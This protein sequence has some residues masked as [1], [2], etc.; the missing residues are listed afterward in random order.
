MMQRE[1][2]NGQISKVIQINIAENFF[3]RLFFLSRFLSRFN[4][5]VLTT[6]NVTY[7]FVLKYILNISFTNKS[8]LNLSY[9]FLIFLLILRFLPKTYKQQKSKISHII[10]TYKGYTVI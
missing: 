5:Y 1:Q 3:L 4:N 7:S 9:V 2:S 10:R 6:T 8:G